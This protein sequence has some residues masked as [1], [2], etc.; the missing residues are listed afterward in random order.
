M[1][2]IWKAEPTMILAVVSA[3]ISL[4]V[5]FGLHITTQQMGLI[6]AFAA[7]VLGLI[8]R[9]QVISP[10]TLQTMTP[11][12]LADAQDTAKPVADVVKKLP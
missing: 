8:N 11:K 10:A 7:A 2:S 1:N 4:G 3:G 9:S 12:T 5:G 6:M